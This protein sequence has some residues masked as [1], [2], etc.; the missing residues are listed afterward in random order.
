M[1]KIGCLLILFLLI[2]IFGGILL[3]SLFWVSIDENGRCNYK[4]LVAPSDACIDAGSYS[5]QESSKENNT[6]T[7]TPTPTP[8]VKEG[9]LLYETSEY[10][11]YYPEE[12]FLDEGE[13]FE[14]I[15]IISE[16]ELGLTTSAND[17]ISLHSE[18]EYLEL[19]D[20][21]CQSLAQDSLAD[22]KQSGTYDSIKL[23]DADIVN[24]DYE[25]ACQM[26]FSAVVQGVALDQIIYAVPDTRAEII[27]YIITTTI[28]GSTNDSTVQEIVNSFQLKTTNVVE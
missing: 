1:K 19:T 3:I 5:E 6:T 7:P 24:L 16:F 23:M 8:D 13:T 27:H 18:N 17:N 22:L 9:Y 12:W 14:D 26:T 4:G 20:V 2:I 28:I 21:A 15:V 11:I 25:T 10:S